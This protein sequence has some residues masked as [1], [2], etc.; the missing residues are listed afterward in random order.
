M[1]KKIFMVIGGF[2]VLLLGYLVGGGLSKRRGVQRTEQHLDD[3]GSAIDSGRAGIEAAQGELVD[4]AERVD[5]LADSLGQRQD[6]ISRG[7]EILARAKDRGDTR[8]D[9]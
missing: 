7:R 5:R 9:S 2:A 6:L 3:A 1:V 8:D 4:G